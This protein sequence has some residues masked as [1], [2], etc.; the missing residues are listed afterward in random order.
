MATQLPAIDQ[1]ICSDWSV[2]DKDLYYKMPYWMIEKELT[3]RRK[4]GNWKKIL[5]KLQW[6]PNMGD[7]MR[8]VMSE[9]PPVLRQHAFPEALCSPAKKDITQHRERILDVTLRHHK[10]ESPN[11]CWCPSFQDFITGKV[12]KNLKYVMEQQELF[13]ALFYRSHIFHQSPVVI[14]ADAG[15]LEVDYGAPQGDGNAAGTSGKSLNYLGS[16]LKEIGNP[17]NLSMTLLFR[18]LSIMEEDLMAVP[19]QSGSVKDDSFLNDK[20][21]L[22]TSAE[23]YNNFVNDPWLKENKT[24]S[25]NI[26]TDG[27]KGLI[28]GRITTSLHSN[29]LRIH[30]DTDG[31]ASFPA[32]HTV[33]ENASA[34]NFGQTVVNPTYRDAQFEVAFLCGAEAYS[35]VNVGPP[36]S[37]FAS[38]G[39]GKLGRMQWN[40]KPFITDR[41]NVP[42]VSGTGTVIWEPNTY[43]EFLKIVAHNVFGI[44]GTVKRNIVPIIFK[45]TRGISTTRI[46]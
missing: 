21:L 8:V 26:V 31:V 33:E 3:F 1:N 25:L 45:R 18:A 42:C 27:F 30:V 22:L 35:V 10:F 28:H 24:D 40:G 6:K 5:G 38:G 34:D 43:N 12:A 32:P 29:P 16:R 9:P 39:V 17:G 7:T 13:E 37:E 44:G 19:Y 11:F 23:A 15:T 2:Q 4:Y 41:I 20:F 36:P 14:F 46:S